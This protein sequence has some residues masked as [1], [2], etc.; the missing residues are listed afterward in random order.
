M[1]LCNHGQYMKKNPY[2]APTDTS[3]SIWC[4]IW[5]KINNTI[6]R[7]RHLLCW[8][9]A[10]APGMS[11]TTRFQVYLSQQQTYVKEN[12][13]KTAHFTFHI[14]T[15]ERFK[16]NSKRNN[17]FRVELAWNGLIL[18]WEEMCVMSDVQRSVSMV[19][20]HIVLCCC[21]RCLKQKTVTQQQSSGQS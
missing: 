19:C 15:W 5:G 2:A 4:Y 20:Q 14:S 12:C 8:V 1:Q 9:G 18:V 16:Y 17:K 6:K 10:C 13:R 3:H 7:K 21:W 11:G